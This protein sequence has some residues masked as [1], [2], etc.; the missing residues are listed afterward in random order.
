MWNGE[1][2]ADLG[3]GPGATLRGNVWALAVAPNERLYAGGEFLSVDGEPLPSCVARWDGAAWQAVGTN[4]RSAS[5]FG[6]CALSLAF[7]PD[8]SLYAGG[9][10]HVGDDPAIRGVAR[11]DGS[12]WTALPSTFPE[13]GVWALRFGSDGRLYSGRLSTPTFTVWNGSDW[14]VLSSSGAVF[15]LA[16]DAAGRLL[17]A[18]NFQE[19]GGVASPN[20]IGY[21]PLLVSSDPPPADTPFAVYPNPT[22]GPATIRTA[23]GGRAEVLDALGRVVWSGEVVPGTTSLLTAG[24]APGVYVVRLTAGDATTSRRLVVGR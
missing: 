9:Y 19:M 18:G 6:D 1:S 16:Q 7:G 2:W 12:T 14:D 22:S 8:G 17:L 20:V 13:P 24:L 3:A 4:L 15:A 21:D 11:W 23:V 10:F 5:T